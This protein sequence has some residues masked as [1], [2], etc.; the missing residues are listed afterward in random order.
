MHK[1]NLSWTELGTA[2]PQ[3]VFFNKFTLIYAPDPKFSSPPLPSVSIFPDRVQNRN[4]IPY[5]Y[6]LPP[7]LQHFCSHPQYPTQTCILSMLINKRILLSLA[8]P[9]RGQ[10][11]ACLY[12]VWKACLCN[13]LTKPYFLDITGRIPDNFSFFREQKSKRYSLGYMKPN[14][15][16]HIIQHGC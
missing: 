1:D 7:L 5:P 2:Q 8:K 13:F 15:S 14:L 11:A 3:L 16:N 12:K 4:T 9:G 6:P 10:G